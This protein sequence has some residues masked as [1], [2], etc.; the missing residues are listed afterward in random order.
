MNMFIGDAEQNGANSYKHSHNNRGFENAPLKSVNNFRASDGVAMTAVSFP[1][2][3]FQQV[4]IKQV[5]DCGEFAA[6]IQG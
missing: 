3:K 6:A 1:N 2:H 4:P 5:N